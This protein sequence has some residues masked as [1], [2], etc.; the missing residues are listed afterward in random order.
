MSII[1]IDPKDIKPCGFC[2]G[3]AIIKEKPLWNG[4]HGYHGCY[5]YY[6]ECTKCHITRPGGSFNTI[7]CDS[8]EEAIKKAI[9]HWN[10]RG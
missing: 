2:N 5:D 10:K 6:V 8:K 4:S 7:V 9:E 3:K 1:M